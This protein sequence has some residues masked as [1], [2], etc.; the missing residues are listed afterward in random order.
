MGTRKPN[1]PLASQNTVTVMLGAEYNAGEN[2]MPFTAHEDG[3]D[4]TG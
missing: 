2:V 3:L 4:R 1:V